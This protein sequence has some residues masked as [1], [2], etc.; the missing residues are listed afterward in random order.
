[1]KS[2]I[3]ILGI[4]ALPFNTSY[5]ANDCKVQNVNQQEVTLVNADSTNQITWATAK[6]K[7]LNSGVDITTEETVFFNPTAVIK[8]THS[9]SIEETVI[10]N[11]LITESQEET[12]Q[13]L[14]IEKTQ[15]DYINED[16]QIIESN[17]NNQVYPLDFEAINRSMKNEKVASNNLAVTVDLKL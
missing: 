5:A 12:T 15:L 13:P 6:H 3:I 9:K 8:V 2:T 1:M 16:N 10:E 11:K 17:P 7:L 14:S 4:A